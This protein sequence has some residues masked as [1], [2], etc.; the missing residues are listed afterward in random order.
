MRNSRKRA[1]SSWI[2]AM[3]A[4]WSRSICIISNWLKGRVSATAELGGV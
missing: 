2:P 1:S 4:P 3:A